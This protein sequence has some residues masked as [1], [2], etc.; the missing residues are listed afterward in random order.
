MVRRSTSAVIIW[1]VRGSR[2]TPPFGPAENGRELT[3]Y[4]IRLQLLLL[5][6]SRRH[7]LLKLMATR[8]HSI[9]V[10]ATLSL[11]IALNYIKE[12]ID[13]LTVSNFYFITRN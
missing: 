12:D 3:V 6:L 7:Q 5:P 10:D 4:C 1:L 8:R 13:K 2:M 9:A 11:R